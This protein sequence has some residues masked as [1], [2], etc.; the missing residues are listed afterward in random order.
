MTRLPD[1]DQY[2]HGRIE[3][4]DN[5]PLLPEGHALGPMS[6]LGQEWNRADPLPEPPDGSVEALILKLRRTP[7]AETGLDPDDGWR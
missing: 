4:S 5:G 1:R 3:R 6:G 2:L 7:V